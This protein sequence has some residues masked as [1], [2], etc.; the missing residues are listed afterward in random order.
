M[1]RLTLPYTEVEHSDFT[2]QFTTN[3]RHTKGE[4]KCVADVLSH[5][6]RNAA[7]SRV[8]EFPPTTIPQ[9]QNRSCAEAVWSSLFQCGQVTATTNASTVICGISV[10]YL[11]QLSPLLIY[12]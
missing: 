9:A 3:L 12:V 4:A 7:T 1:P 5:P 2:S 10:V 8:P 6:Q 11:N